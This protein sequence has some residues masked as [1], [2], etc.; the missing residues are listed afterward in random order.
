MVWAEPVIADCIGEAYG[1]YE[2]GAAFRSLISTHH[3]R[4]WRALILENRPLIEQ[5]RDELT[6]DLLRVG[7][8]ADVVE[9]IDNSIMEELMDIVFKRFRSSREAAKGFSLVLLSAASNIG[10]SRP[11]AA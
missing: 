2:L 1:D 9:D 10:A 7:I 6:R 5:V 4:L 3:R 11:L 8:H